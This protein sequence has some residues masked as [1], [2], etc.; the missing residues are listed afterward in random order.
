M[1]LT[2]FKPKSDTV[3]VI[4]RNPSTLEPLTHD[5]GKEFSITVAAQHT[6]EFKDSQQVNMDLWLNISEKSK[7]KKNPTLS[8]MEKATSEH[9]A[10]IT[11][12]WDLLYNKEKPKL[13][14]KK[15]E[16]IY[17]ELPWIRD[18]IQEAID[19]SVDFTTV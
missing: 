6:K 2:D 8:Q 10:R 12:D 11:L 5:D 7:K 15:A 16:E 9:L 1:D 13:S 17:S 4:L 3:E 18:Q 19:D 14:L